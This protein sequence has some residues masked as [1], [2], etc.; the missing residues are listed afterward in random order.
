MQTSIGGHIRSSLSTASK[1]P[2]WR[3]CRTSLYP[4]A[5]VNSS[6]ATFPISFHIISVIQW[7]SSPIFV[8]LV[9]IQSD[10]R[11]CDF[12]VSLFVSYAHAS[13]TPSLLL[14]CESWISPDANFLPMSAC[15]PR[16]ANNDPL[17]AS[18]FT[19]D[20]FWSL[21]LSV[22]LSSACYNLLCSFC[23]SFF[24]FKYICTTFYYKSYWNV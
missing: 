11:F 8:Q 22:S 7:L 9:C 1:S 14:S 17:L 24:L 4:M 16:C 5:N 3:L 2:W 23:L 18:Y 15:C 20:G 13:L 6:F 21:I 19:W 12:C 10:Y